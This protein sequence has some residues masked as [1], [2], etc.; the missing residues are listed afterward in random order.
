MQVLT[1]GLAFIPGPEAVI[2]KTLVAA[3]AQS[4]F[5]TKFAVPMG[6]TASEQTTTI[7]DL[8]ANAS[9][10]MA[11]MQHNIARML[12]VLLNDVDNFRAAASNGVMSQ[13]LPSLED[14]ATK[15]MQGLNTYVISLAYQS[16]GVFI[17]RALNTS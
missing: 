1:S 7:E 9:S 17:V 12:P 2:G 3:I 8:S 13:F 16:R 10:F 4:G 6:N 15:T 11:E 5:I 14:L